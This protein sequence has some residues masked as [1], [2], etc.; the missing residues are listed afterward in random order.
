MS[1]KADDGG[2]ESLAL[3][4]VGSN[5]QS[6]GRTP[7]MRPCFVPAKETHEESPGSVLQG[8]GRGERGAWEGFR[9]AGGQFRSLCVPKLAIRGLLKRRR[10]SCCKEKIMPTHR[11]MPQ[12]FCVRSIETS[13]KHFPMHKRRHDRGS[14]QSVSSQDTILDSG[15]WCQRKQTEKYRRV[16]RKLSRD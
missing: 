12:V 11:T 2:P 13:T 15:N 9:P 14:R 8:D 7:S 6:C 10:N 3:M 16:L 5:F 4:S 1:G